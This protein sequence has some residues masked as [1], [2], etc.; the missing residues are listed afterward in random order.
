MK[1]YVFRMQPD[2]NPLAADKLHKQA[3]T[4]SWEGFLRSRRRSLVCLFSVDAACLEG[5]VLLN[6]AAC[7]EEEA[8]TQTAIF[9]SALGVNCAVDSVIGI[10]EDEAYP[11]LMKA[12]RCGFL[13]DMDEVVGAFG[14]LRMRGILGEIRTVDTTC[15]QC[16]PKQKSKQF[17][18]IPELEREI[19]RILE[20]GST[21]PHMGHPVH[22]KLEMGKHH[23]H[24]EAVDVLLSSLY[25]KRRIQRKHYQV[26]RF[27]HGIP[28]A[29]EAIQEAAESAIGGALVLDFITH[30]PKEDTGD[31][32]NLSH[33]IDVCTQAGK[34]AKQVLF[35]FCF[36]E[37]RDSEREIFED[38]LA[39]VPF[40]FIGQER[41]KGEQA[42]TY[43]TELAER[44]GATAD[45]ALYELVDA[46]REG[47][48]ETELQLQYDKWYGGYLRRVVY[49]LYDG[50]QCF[51]NKAQEKVE[52]RS[53]NCAEQ[54][55]YDRLQSFVGLDS[56]KKT[57]NRMLNT[58]RAR[59]LYSQHGVSGGLQPMHMVFSGNPGT[60]KTSVAR[61]YAQILREEGILRKGELIEV[62]RA[63]LVGKYVGWTARLVREHIRK[64]KGSVLFID[65]AYS[66][67][68]GREGQFGEEAINT[69][70]MEMENCR[71]DTLIILAGYPD[72]MEDLLRFNP[73][74]RSRIGFHISFEDYSPD[75]MLQ[76]LH[77]MAEEHG[78]CL[79]KGVDQLM[80]PCLE[81]AARMAEAG[82]GRFVRNLLDAARMKQA[83]RL[84][85]LDSEA[86]TDDCV[87]TLLPQDFEL[88]LLQRQSRALIG[89]QKPTNEVSNAE[90]TAQENAGNTDI[91][92]VEQAQRCRPSPDTAGHCPS[93]VVGAWGAG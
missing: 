62:S 31:Y 36:A 52:K 58:H 38:M 88:P 84:L 64:A 34:S 1:C 8:R 20:P 57:I 77:L 80:R 10:S 66:L 30:W 75:E 6:P 26:L 73:G 72:Q 7:Q 67:L 9:L 33:M 35:F 15:G 47:F 76:I 42:K 19:C 61:L 18:Q 86:L 43:L 46:G 32:P 92:C 51:D 83:E 59:K 17:P 23:R 91:G 54:T 25:Q 28:M 50:L 69:L 24:M 89:F 14:V 81:Q 74:L 2:L 78:F 16:G 87:R 68:S 21:S 48:L 53:L 63:D 3:G 65:E 85:H 29:E 40:L 12:F 56:A 11:I 22:Y 27:Q 60:A 13:R 44:D 55:A 49:P 70:V 71:G 93:S 37:Y 82:N 5:I 79:D 90:Q 41:M 45:P 4:I 39:D